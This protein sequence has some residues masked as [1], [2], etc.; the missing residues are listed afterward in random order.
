MNFLVFLQA[1]A[2]A[3]A[4]GNWTFLA[5]MVLIFVVMYFF[6]IRPQQKKQKELVKFRDNLKKGD[7]VLTAG[8]I[9]GVVVEVKD[10]YVLVEVD[11]NVKIRFD[12]SAI[13]SEV[14]DIQSTK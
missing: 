2:A 3:G 8:G 6:M 4:G 14:A 7:K 1:A 5:M 10:Q 11:A 9:Y 12:K 13:V